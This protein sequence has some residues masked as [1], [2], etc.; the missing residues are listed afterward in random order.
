MGISES[1]GGYSPASYAGAVDAAF[2]RVSRE[3]Q[4]LDRQR[5]LAPA[6]LSEL[7]GLSQA[8]QGLLIRN[9][10]KYQSW[11]IAEQ[12]L[13]A[14]RRVWT[15]NPREGE[16]LAWVASEIADTLSVEGFRERILND[17]KA[18][19]W[20][21]VGNCRRIQAEL[22]RADEAFSRGAAYL[23]AGT[24]D[25]F[26]HAQFDALRASLLR[27]RRQFQRASRLLDTVV[28][29]YREAGDKRLEARSLLVLGN[30]LIDSGE[31]E[32]SLS[33]I[34]RAIRLLQGQ[35]EPW[36]NFV[37]K[38]QFVVALN[39]AG[40]AVEAQGYLAELRRLVRE[41]GNRFDRLRVLW[42]EGRVWTLLGRYELA[43]EALKQVRAGFIDAEIGYDVALVSLDLSAL[44]LETGRTAEVK[45]LAAEMLPQF[46]ARQIHREALAAITLFEQ[47]ARKER[48]TLA[49]VKEVSAKVKDASTRRTPPQDD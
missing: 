2:E 34:R 46:A 36:L 32:Q 20:S 30:V 1:A 29:T 6:L 35:D 39:E 15:E 33:T 14:S 44:Y 17:L 3:G 21:Y 25:P 23:E 12:L 4:E 27:D 38:H 41:V 10:P 8:Q 24:G 13:E 47:A 49:L 40:R 26:E 28:R 37:A 22:R 45:E 43:E 7:G 48:A 42:T 19:A 16:R 5:L 11:A 31:F 18:E 9:S